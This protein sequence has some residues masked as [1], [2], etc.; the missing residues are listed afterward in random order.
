MSD[1][2]AQSILDQ[3][4]ACARAY[5]FPMLDNAYIFL[6]S[7]RLT[8]YHDTTRWA[9]LIEV[10]GFSPKSGYDAERISLDLYGFG[11]CLHQRPGLLAVIYPATAS[12]PLFEERWPGRLIPGAHTLTL[13]GREVHI[14]MDRQAYQAARIA[15]RSPDALWGFEVL[16]VLLPEHRTLLLSTEAER[17]AHIPPNLPEILQL[18]DW[19]HPDLADD[20]LPGHTETFRQLAAVLCTGDPAHYAPSEPPNTDWRHWPYGGDGFSG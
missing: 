15:L 12:A 18:D 3:L 6:A 7:A 4:D 13:R 8:L 19:R 16:R 11:N 2:T 17:R 14:P 10:L 1:Y 5:T 9:L 20:E